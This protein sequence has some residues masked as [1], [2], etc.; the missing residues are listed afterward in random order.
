M[1]QRK[2]ITYLYNKTPNGEGSTALPV[3]LNQELRSSQKCTENRRASV[4]RPPIFEALPL[5]C[6]TPINFKQDPKD[7][8]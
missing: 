1:N 6:V 4:T 3:S 7:L 2:I 5:N 8:S